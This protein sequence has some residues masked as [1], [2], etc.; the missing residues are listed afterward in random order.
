[1]FSRNIYFRIFL[2]IVIAVA[3]SIIAVLV[4]T[5]EAAH[6]QAGVSLN[7]LIFVYPDD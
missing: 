4:T 6:D 2:G 5:G 3:A 1:M 7:V